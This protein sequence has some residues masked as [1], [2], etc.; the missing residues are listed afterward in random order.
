MTMDDLLVRPSPS[1][2]GAPAQPGPETTG[3]P[4]ERGRRDGAW[5]RRSASARDTW[6]RLAA[7]DHFDAL[8]LV[9]LVVLALG[10]RWR[11]MWASY[12]GDEAIAIGIALAPRR[13]APSLPGQRRLAAPVLPD[14]PLL[15]GAVRPVHAGHSRPVDDRRSAGHTGGLV[16][17]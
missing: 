14:A 7:W 11:T 15:D 10:L 2:P 6:E 16:V 9:A 3:R 13:F 8:L 17:R 4:N 5:K 1:P 12:W